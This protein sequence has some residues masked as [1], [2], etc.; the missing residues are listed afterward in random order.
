MKAQMVTATSVTSAWARPARRPLLLLAAL[1]AGAALLGQ[2]S[3]AR[4]QG[5]V[6]FT[7]MVVEHCDKMASVCTW[8]LSC[9]VGAAHSDLVSGVKAGT[10]VHAACTGTV[11]TARAV[12]GAGGVVTLLCGPWRVTH[13][14]LVAIAVRPGLR[15][16]AGASHIEIA[17]EGAGRGL[18]AVVDDGQGMPPEDVRLALDRHATSKLGDRATLCDP[19]ARGQPPS[20]STRARQTRSAPRRP[21]AAPTRV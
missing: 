5:R 17:V 10:A 6:A 9:G 18:V 20:G 8:K 16:H 4:A 14:P 3:A 15:V 13:L 19:G 21:R 2:P 11:V 7:K 12:A 1:L